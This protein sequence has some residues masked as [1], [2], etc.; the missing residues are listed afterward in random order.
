MV[1]IT[2]T[3]Y[4]GNI[5]FASQYLDLSSRFNK[6]MPRLTMLANCCIAVSRDARF[7][8]PQ[9]WPPNSLYFN[10]VGYAILGILKERVYHL[11]QEPGRDPCALKCTLILTLDIVKGWYGHFKTVGHACQIWSK[12]RHS[13]IQDGHHSKIDICKK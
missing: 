2:G 9:Y 8:G 7:I 13:E 10:P 1:C 3:R 12:F 4:C 5:F 11:V 6:T